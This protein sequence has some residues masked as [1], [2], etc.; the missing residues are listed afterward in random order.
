MVYSEKDT[1]DILEQS[2]FR[3]PTRMFLITVRNE[4]YLIVIKFTNLSFFDFSLNENLPDRSL[5]FIWQIVNKPDQKIP[6]SEASWGYV[7]SN[8]SKFGKKFGECQAT[9]LE[10]AKT[11]L[12]TGTCK[13]LLLEDG[14]GWFHLAWLEKYFWG[15]FDAGN[16]NNYKF[17][18]IETVNI[19]FQ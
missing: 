14:K 12:N 15:C 8:T 9:P 16:I 7:L 4:P 5:P 17:T 6:R 2:L 10:L 11:R 19:I 18:K 3:E 13:Y 1:G